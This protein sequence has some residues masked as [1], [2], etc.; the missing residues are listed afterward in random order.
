MTIEQIARD[1]RRR[2]TGRQRSVIWMASEGR[3][4]DCGVELE[5]GWEAHHVER[6]ADGGPTN[7]L[8]G[9]ALCKPCHQRRHAKVQHQFHKDYSWQ[10]RALE[11]FWRDI[12]TYCSAA[13]GQFQ[14]AFT[15]EVSPSGGKTVFALKLARRM[16][17]ADLIDRVIIVAPRDNIKDGFREDCQRV[18][19]A[20][21][22]RAVPS[23]QYIRISTSVDPKTTGLMKNY[24]GGVVLYQSLGGLLEYFEMIGRSH[25]LLFIFDEAHHGSEDDSDQF[26]KWGEAMHNVRSIAHSVVC[27]SG[28]PMRTDGNALPLWDYEPP[29]EDGNQYVVPSFRFPYR[30]AVRA[31]IARKVAIRVL[32]PE[33]TAREHTNHGVMEVTQALSLFTADDAS[34]IKSAFL[35]ERGDFVERALIAAYEEC[36]AQ[37]RRGDADAAILVVL[38]PNRKADQAT[39]EDERNLEVVKRRIFDLFG[40]EALVVSSMDRRSSDRLKAF[41]TTNQRWLVAIN[42]VS[43][44]TNV[45]RV[46]NI[47]ILREIKSHVLYQQLVHR[48]TR[49]DSDVVLEHAV[50]FQPAFPHMSQWGRELEDDVRAALKARGSDDRDGGQQD[51]FCKHCREELDF[52]PNYVTRLCPNGDCPSNQPGFEI[53]FRYIE[54]LAARP[55]EAPTTHVPNL[56]EYDNE[57]YEVSRRLHIPMP[58]DCT[59]HPVLEAV[60]GLR[61]RGIDI[62]G[63][64][65]DAPADE[66][67]DERCKRLWEAGL[68]DVRAAAMI[69]G[70]RRGGDQQEIIRRITHRAKAMAGFSGRKWQDVLA[71]DRD[72]EGKF[73]AF[74]NQAA[75]FLKGARGHAA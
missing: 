47:V 44:G 45:K 75:R 11:A 32:D 38:R 16:I 2:F 51:P 20:D 9:Q 23:E 69:E 56:G 74:R 7:E 70:E 18:P 52:W 55:D 33:V 1:A 68:K 19:M 62:S 50:V 41:K 36:E 42:L 72:C 43:E 63:V 30:D 31:N 49:N 10:D 48:A 22:F 35:D 25:R 66:P 59:F 12:D 21:A 4:A 60:K 24:H 37:R 14:K 53:D 67:L 64:T 27:L 40:E 71:N 5:Q 39:D 34:R 13:P 6:H 57:V 65:G 28:T 3:C 73:Q 17:E 54:A 29:D 46:R 61:D 58:P 8:N 26:S 15:V